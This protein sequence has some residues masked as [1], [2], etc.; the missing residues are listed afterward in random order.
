[1]TETPTAMP[2]R[3][4]PRRKAPAD[5]APWF[6]RAPNGLVRR[7]MRVGLPMG[8][9]V[10]MTV[11]GRTSGQPRTVP[12]AVS[13]INGRRYV[14]GAYGDVQWVR[15]LRAAGEATIRLK[16]EE[17]HVTATELDPVAAHAFF[18]ETIPGYI[19][20]FPRLGRAFLRALFR[21]VAPDLL[22]DPDKAAA[23][24]PVFELRPSTPG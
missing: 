13:E 7:L 9:N 18:A 12:V 17:V 14:I 3:N 11:R 22:S 16:G 19:A 4:L 15:N 5:Q 21:L 6:V 20:H 2:R 23:T 10:P 8:P 1:M 24:R